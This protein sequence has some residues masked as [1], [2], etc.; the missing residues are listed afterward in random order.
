[1]LVV[2]YKSGG[3][4]PGRPG[5]IFWFCHHLAEWAQIR[6]SVSLSLIFLLSEEAS[7][8]ALLGELDSSPPALQSSLLQWKLHHY[9]CRHRHWKYRG[10]RLTRRGPP[11]GTTHKE[12]GSSP[13]WV[14]GG[15]RG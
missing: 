12:A 8:L 15:M 13:C 1:M 7:F 10:R 3:L 11:I 6:S 4:E 14:V 2:W 5:S 9:A